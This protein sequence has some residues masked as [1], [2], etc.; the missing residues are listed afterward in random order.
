ARRRPTFYYTEN[1]GVGRAIQR[2][3]AERPSIRIGAIGLGAGT[4]AAYLRPAD[5][6][7]FWDIDP[8]IEKVAR[9]HF[10]FLADSPGK[11]RVELADGRRALASS[12][13]DFDLILMDA[14]MGDGVPSHL[15]TR[16]ALL[17]YQT[18]LA[19]RDGLLVVH[20]SMRYSNLFPVVAVTASTF[21]WRAFAV[22]TEINAATETEDW[23]A[24][25]S[26]Y[27]LVAPAAKFAKIK[28]WFEL[29]DEGE[30]RVLREITELTSSHN[31]HRYVWLDD[32]QSG[33]DTL[34]LNRYLF[35]R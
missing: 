31:S 6:I 27:I 10:S 21:N 24:R 14:F 25:E 1:S 11:V 16:Q 19:A 20:A 5:E 23:D 2:L 4:L 30:G 17:L 32:R 9:E 26:T 12:E 3:Q 8:K 13:E 7:V 35:G 15:L 18:R 28:S 33:L 29:L 34:D 22:R